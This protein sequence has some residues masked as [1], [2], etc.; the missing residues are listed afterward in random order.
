MASTSRKKVEKLITGCLAYEGEFLAKI[1]IGSE[2]EYGMA[3][4][5]LDPILLDV[6][7]NR[8]NIQNT[9]NQIIMGVEINRYARPI[10]YWFRQDNYSTYGYM[11]KHIRIPAEH[12]IHIMTDDFPNQVRGIPKMST[13]LSGLN[14]LAAYS[15]AEIIA[16]RVSASKMGYY[17][18]N[19]D[20]EADYQA[21]DDEKR[22]VELS[23]ELEPG[24]LEKLPAGWD[25]GF[26]D[27][28]HPNGNH[29]DFTKVQLREIANGLDVAYNSLGNDLEGVNFSSIRQ[30][31]LEEREGWMDEQEDI[32]DEF[33]RV[34]FRK[35]ITINLLNGKLSPLPYSKISKFINCDKWLARRWPW[36]DPFKDAKTN[37]LMV[38]RGWKTNSDVTGEQGGD[39]ADNIVTLSKE[40]EHKEAHGFNSLDKDPNIKTDNVIGE[41]K[42]ADKKDKNKKTDKGNAN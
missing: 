5:I 23:T 12:I 8:R 38:D 9:E 34:I 24:T 29:K 11:D 41:N 25:M 18:S 37:E 19:D 36:V 35:F 16:A 7:L 2:Y 3:V 31:V 32:I 22:T 26:F 15:E 20:A 6:D 39:Y 17:K 27:P 13:S 4:Q 42:D 21:S 30:G 40:I 28:K 1:V 14:N 33:E 10:A